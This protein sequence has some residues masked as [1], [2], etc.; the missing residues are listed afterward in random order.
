MRAKCKPPAAARSGSRVR[1][2]EEGLQI[3]RCIYYPRRDPEIREAAE[4]LTEI[5][6]LAPDY[7]SH[8]SRTVNFHP[9][10]VV[11]RAAQPRSHPIAVIGFPPF[12]QPNR[13]Q[14]VSIPNPV[15]PPSSFFIH[16]AGQ[17]LN[18]TL[19]A[20]RLVVVAQ[21]H[22]SQSGL[23]MIDRIFKF[24]SR[25]RSNHFGN[26]EKDG[27]KAVR[28]AIEKCRANVKQ[29]LGRGRMD[30]VIMYVPNPFRHPIKSL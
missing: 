21:D 29:A 28:C 6:A 1:I 12:A 10:R 3:V 15:S 7:A 25:T 14:R 9:L 26:V 4:G 5:G 24:I 2:I 22:T 8:W 13:A 19:G 23:P 27:V 17:H 20:S 16:R 30:W 11:P 18:P